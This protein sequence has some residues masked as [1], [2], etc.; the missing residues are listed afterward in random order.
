MGRHEAIRGQHGRRDRE[1]SRH[2]GMTSSQILS[3]D[4]ARDSLSKNGWK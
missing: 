4:I 3:L 1:A 2:G